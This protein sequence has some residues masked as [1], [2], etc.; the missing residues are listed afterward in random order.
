MVVDAV[1]RAALVT[2]V[3]EYVLKVPRENVARVSLGGAEFAK[4]KPRPK[5]ENVRAVGDA[6]EYGWQDDGKREIEDEFDGVSF[7]AGEGIGV[8]VGMMFVVEILEEVG[9]VH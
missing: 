4:E 3:F 6:S 7:A 1:H 8:K 5:G 2:D 9:N